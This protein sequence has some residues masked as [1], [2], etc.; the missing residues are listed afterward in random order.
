MERDALKTFQ[1]DLLYSNNKVSLP[2][3]EDRQKHYAT[4]ATDADKI[5]DDNLDK[6]CNQLQNE[7]YYMIL[8]RFR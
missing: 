8:L 2:T 6:F 4:Q 5:T 3:G 7:Y 1:N